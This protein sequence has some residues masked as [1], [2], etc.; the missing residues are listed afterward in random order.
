MVAKDSVRKP[1]SGPKP[2]IAT[3]RIATM[4]SCKARE[5]AM[6]ARQTR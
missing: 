6:I 1:A 4:I 2:K 5:M 3:R